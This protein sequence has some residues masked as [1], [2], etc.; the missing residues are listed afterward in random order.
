MA[1]QVLGGHALDVETDPQLSLWLG[2]SAACHEA[3]LPGYQLFFQQVG[4]GRHT[5]RDPGH[6]ITP[7][8]GLQLGPVARMSFQRAPST[9]GAVS[10]T[11][12]LVEFAYVASRVPP[13]ACLT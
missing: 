11:N 10:S 1:G 7:G 8:H 9:N 12:I 2:S 3:L 13:C 4:S 5:P 6:L